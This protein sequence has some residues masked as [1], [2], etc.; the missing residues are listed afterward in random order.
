MMRALLML[1]AL[2]ISTPAMAFDISDFGFDTTGGDRDS[3]RAKQAQQ[4]LKFVQAIVP[5]SDE[6]EIILGRRV[7]ARVITRYGIENNS[8]STYYLNLMATAIAQRSDRPNI[9]YHVAIL[10]TDDV[11]AYA[12]PGGYIFVTRGVLNM[13]RDEA[14]LAAVLAHEI[15]HVT[16]R[17]IIKA[18]QQSKLMQ[19]GAEVAA[20]AFRKSGPLLEKMT[21]FATDALFKGLKK[22]DEYDSDKKAVEYL[23]RIGYDYPAM[24]D[25]LKLLEVRRKQGA[26]KVLAKTHPSPTTRSQKLKT[27]TAKLSLQTPTGIRLPNRFAQHIRP[28]QKNAS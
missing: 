1:L 14:E 27:A 4:V 22:S 19:V 15:S 8:E 5:I 25:V 13:V 11:N 9:P 6:E 12:C 2:A 28:S 18:L 20:D 23:D 3:K 7:A 16:E 21:S 24:F 26:T 10:A 17:H